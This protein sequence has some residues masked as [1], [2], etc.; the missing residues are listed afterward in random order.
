VFRWLQQ[1]GGVSDHE[2]RR[3][4]NCGVGFMLIVA[5]ENV[6]PVLAALLNAGETAFPCGQLQAA[7]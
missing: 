6:E 3:T 7:A 5:P 1:T 2:L 4:F